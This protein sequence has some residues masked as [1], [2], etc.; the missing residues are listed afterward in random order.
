MSVSDL[1]VGL[2][3]KPPWVRRGLR[4]LV[5]IPGGLFLVPDGWT[6]GVGAVLM[7]SDDGAVRLQF[8]P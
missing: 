5:A 7:I 2:A 1:R 6:P 8:T 4:L 3:P